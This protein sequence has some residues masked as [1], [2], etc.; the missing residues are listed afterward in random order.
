MFN[1]WPKGTYMPELRIIGPPFVIE[2]PVAICYG[3]KIFVKQYLQAQSI[4]FSIFYVFYKGECGGLLVRQGASPLEKDLAQVGPRLLQAQSPVRN[5]NLLQS[6]QPEEPDREHGP[7]IPRIHSEKPTRG[8]CHESHQTW[9]EIF[10]Q[11][12]KINQVFI[13]MQIIFFFRCI[14]MAIYLSHL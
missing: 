13:L 3:F 5:Q 1:F 8:S 7:H 4:E 10:P 9:T 2:W 6:Y 12:W 11:T 14:Q